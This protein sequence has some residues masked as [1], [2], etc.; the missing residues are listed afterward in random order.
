MNINPP[1]QGLTR[2]LPMDVYFSPLACSLASRITIYE[3]GLTANFDRV[4]TKAMRASAPLVPVWDDHE[5]T[6]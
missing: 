6:K 2:S 3:A 1:P 5:Y 4:D